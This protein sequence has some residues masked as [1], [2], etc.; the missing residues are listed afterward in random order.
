M[1]KTLIW[2][3]LLLSIA[4]LLIRFSPIIEQ[5]ILGIKPKS[6]ISI[7]STPDAA[8]VFLD[9][10]EMGKTPYDNKDL[11]VRDYLV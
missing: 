8:T 1:K 9:D 4:T 3:L 11:E 10:K 7:L 6:G 5:I 2:I